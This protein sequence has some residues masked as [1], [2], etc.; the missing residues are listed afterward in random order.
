M[1]QKQQIVALSFFIL[2]LFAGGFGWQTFLNSNS[3]HYFNSDISRLMDNQN[4]FLLSYGLFS[5]HNLTEDKQKSFRKIIELKE[6]S[7]KSK[8]ENFQKL[9]R[10]NFRKNQLITMFKS[11]EMYLVTK[12][13]LFNDNQVLGFNWIRKNIPVD[14]SIYD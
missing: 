4:F 11:F 14:Q 6:P 5:E 1:T 10:S 9:C 13:N 12:Q 8:I 3:C 2:L 7:I